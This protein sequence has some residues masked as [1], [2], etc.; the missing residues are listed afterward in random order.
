MERSP[1]W[2]KLSTADLGGLTAHM[3]WQNIESY[4]AVANVQLAR[5][6]DNNYL[7]ALIES[8]KATLASDCGLSSDEYQEVRDFQ[9]ARLTADAHFYL[10][11]WRIVALNAFRIA[12]AIPDAR[13]DRF[14]VEQ[15]CGIKKND[16]GLYF[17]Q[18]TQSMT[19][20]WY[21]QGRD[22]FEHIDERIFG[23]DKWERLKVD[24][25]KIS[26]RKGHDGLARPNAHYFP[27]PHFNGSHMI[28]GE[29][30]WEITPTSHDHL[31]GII[32]QLQHI[33]EDLLSELESGDGDAG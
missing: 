17:D 6:Q 4:A 15:Q 33:Y 18:A 2:L 11:C 21:A 23:G 25:S 30:T 28:V 10:N 29:S 32:R 20:G 8:F 16:R 31:A 26:P 1:V 9:F 14:L 3:A 22:H 7:E 5:I 27:S 12:R 24:S 19:L 13:L